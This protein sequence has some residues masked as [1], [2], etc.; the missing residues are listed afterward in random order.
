[1]V[2]NF[3]HRSMRG[4]GTIVAEDACLV[5]S[6]SLDV[7]NASACLLSVTSDERNIARPGRRVPHPSRKLSQSWPRLLLLENQRFHGMTGWPITARS[8]MPSQLPIRTFS[9]TSMRECG[10]RAEFTGHSPRASENGIPRPAS[11]FHHTEIACQRHR[12]SLG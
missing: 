4:T 10:T 9:T 1:M 8:A 2:P 3:D 11:E 12:H 7:A 6:P 5:N